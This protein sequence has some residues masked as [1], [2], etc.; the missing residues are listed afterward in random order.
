MANTYPSPVKQFFDDEG[1]PLAGG[2]LY[3]YAAG[4][5]TPLATYTN[6]GG[7]TANANPIVLDSRGEAAIWLGPAR[8]KLVLKTADDVE[9]WT[10]DN[11]RD[12]NSY[13][14]ETW[15]VV[16]SIAEL[17]ALSSDA[18]TRAFVTG[19][20]SVG[21]GGG[22]FYWYDSSD[23]SS[24]DNGGTVIVATD[25][26]RWKLQHDGDVYFE[27]F[28][29]VGDGTED[30]YPAIS[31]LCA[32]SGV[33][34]GR[35]KPAKTYCVGTLVTL[36]RPNFSLRC[37]INGMASGYGGIIKYIGSST[38]TPLT[39]AFIKTTSG[40]ISQG[41]CGFKLDANSRAEGCL[42]LDVNDG[43]S[44]HNPYAN[45]LYFTGYTGRGLIIG[46]D[47]QVSVHDGQLAGVQLN[48]LRW[49]GNV[50][51]SSGLIV[52]AQNCE[53]ASAT[54]WDF[55]CIVGGHTNHIIAAHGGVF[56]RNMV[57]TRA[58]GYAVVGLGSQVVINGWRSEDRYLCDFTPTG[59]EGPCEVTGFLH[60][61]GSALVGD[62]SINWNYT[63]HPLF[64]RG[65]LLGRVIV[66]PT[67][68][69]YI[70]AAVFFSLGADFVLQ[71]PRNQ[72]GILHNLSTG[73]VNVLG[74]AP[75]YTIQTNDGT[76]QF[77]YN[78]E[79]CIINRPSG[80]SYVA[81]GTSGSITAYLAGLSGGLFQIKNSAGGVR[82]K[83]DSTEFYPGVDSSFN[84]GS[85]SYRWSNIY[86][87][88]GAIVTSDERQ[89]TQ[90]Q[91]ISDA[92]FRAWSKVRFV[93]FKMLQAVEEKGNDGARW[94]FGV[95]AQEIKDAFESE[96]LDA[97]A[98]GLICYDEWGYTYEEVDGETVKVRNAG[99]AYGVRYDEVMA[100]ECAYIRSRI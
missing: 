57:S 14:S 2:L 40:A 45:D 99:N 20:Y 18:I 25:G 29:A 19:Y 44:S 80:D 8:Y 11:I 94:H 31:E 100:M 43:A 81:L 6:S 78:G 64:L 89:K 24:S 75:T 70:D 7:G 48:R 12:F 76:P 74:S 41:I 72:R 49:Y 26:G 71:A 1:N 51:G 91:P 56:V 85:A 82:Y 22:G 33:F 50:A 59:A 5:T 68:A 93:Q 21:D 66:G 36:S 55:N 92:V 35:G 23:T 47:D 95:I 60:R 16:N 17:K 58:T 37:D 34:I 52:N 97:F 39:G 54:L 4:T 98:Y 83:F 84:C 15:Q 38:G 90:I 46:K 88:N 13:L 69:R 73:G 42:H 61:S 32:A 86:A 9:I 27:Q 67:A 10:Q 62:D 63:Q 3:T 79:G 87:S 28:G 96:G 53:F 65:T 30:D 77:V